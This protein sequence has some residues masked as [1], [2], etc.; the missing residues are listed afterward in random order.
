MVWLFRAMPTG[1]ET[2]LEMP[3]QRSCVR[4]HFTESIVPYSGAKWSTWQIPTCKNT[5]TMCTFMPTPPHEQ[6]V[7]R[8]RFKALFKWF[9]I[10]VF[11]FPDGLP[12]HGSRAQSVLLFIH[13][14]SENSWIHTF[15]K[16]ISATCIGNNIIKDWNSFGLVWFGLV[17]F[18]AYQPL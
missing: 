7:T 11:L 4:T 8:S 2:F 3:G 12:Y 15:R 17:G 14:L 9:E 16:T 1:P 10:I 5:P 13:N 18:M 6:D